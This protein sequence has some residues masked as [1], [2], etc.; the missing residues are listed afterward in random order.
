MP[1]HY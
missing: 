1:K